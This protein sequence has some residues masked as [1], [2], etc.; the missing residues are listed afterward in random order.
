M[1]EREAQSIL[2]EILCATV[3]GAEACD[4]VREK[5]TPD[6]LASVYRLAKKHDLAHVV[7][8]FVSQNQIEVEHELLEKL[9]REELASI[10]RYE[11]MKYAYEEIC[12]ALDRAEITYVPLKGSVLRPFY[13]YESM[14]TS[15]DIDI[16]IHESDLAA[17]TDCL[18][19]MG[20]RSGRQN[21]H[22]ISLYAPNQ[23]HLELHFNI[24]EN[25][26]SLDAVLKD[27]WDYAV[28]VEGSRY[29][30]TEPFLAFHI[31]A[32]MA[33][34]FLSGGC[35]IRSL[36]DIW[37]MEYRMGIAYP[38]AKELLEK[39][40][41]YR[42]ASEMSRLAEQCF[43]GQKLDLFGDSV[44]TYIFRGGVYGSSENSMAMYKS[45]EKSSFHYLMERIF[46]PYRSMKVAY[47]V[48]KKVPILLP[49]CWVARWVKALTGGKTKQLAAE[50]SCAKQTTAD[51][52]AK[53]KD[54]CSRL[55]L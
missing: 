51:S 52:A 53:A 26:D 54:V 9:Q 24:Q 21:Y 28:P 5:M 27:A 23:I 20:Y 2:I 30:F 29:A 35:G 44:L 33:Y 13:P 14:R 31:F 43:A 47:P 41:I 32:H 46:L 12:G 38:C 25:M 10:Y 4:A 7:S 42:F 37:I 34:H 55:G 19:A 18:T 3:N 11:Q 16:L 6:G 48:L 39:A 22:D 49:F 36:L 1:D 40:G 45:Q 15:C 17:A 50:M 8:R